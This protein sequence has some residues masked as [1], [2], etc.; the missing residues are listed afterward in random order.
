MPEGLIVPSLVIL[1]EKLVLATQM[2][3]IVVGE[4]LSYP[5]PPF[6][7]AA[8]AAGVPPPIRIAATELDASSSRRFGLLAHR[9]FRIPNAAAIGR[10]PR[11]M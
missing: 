6:T 1:P 11:P 5:P 8:K 7:Q 4:G 9:G 2:P 3:A 10:R